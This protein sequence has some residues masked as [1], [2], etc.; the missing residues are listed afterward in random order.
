MFSQNIFLIIFTI[1]FILMLFYLFNHQLLTEI[2]NQRKRYTSFPKDNNEDC[3]V[4]VIDVDNLSITSREITL[5]T[6][7]RFCTGLTSSI[8]SDSIH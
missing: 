2:Y 3:T 4:F 7:S 8:D 5:R 6:S 1:F